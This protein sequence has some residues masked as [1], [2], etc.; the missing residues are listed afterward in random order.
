MD[1][2]SAMV[3]WYQ[4]WWFWTAGGVVVAGATTGTVLALTAG[5]EAGP[6]DYGI[7]IR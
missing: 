6:V 3:P 2:A 4:T 1:G 7:R 5:G